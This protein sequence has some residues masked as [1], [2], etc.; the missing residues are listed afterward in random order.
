MYVTVEYVWRTLDV[1]GELACSWYTQFTHKVT[2]LLQM[3]RSR[4]HVNQNLMTPWFAYSIKLKAVFNW[5]SPNLHLNQSCNNL[6]IT[7]IREVSNVEC[8]KTKTKPITHQ[9]DCLEWFS[10]ECWKTNLM[11]VIFLANQKRHRQ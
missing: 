11:I 5:V 10:P 6:P 3:W 2:S 7:L 8:C 1:T 9:L 4:L